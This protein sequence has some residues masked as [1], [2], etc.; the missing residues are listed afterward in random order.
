MFSMIISPLTSIVLTGGSMPSLNVAVD[1][2]TAE[3]RQRRSCHFARAP[4]ARKPCPAMLGRF[5]NSR[6]TN[7]PWAPTKKCG[8]PWCPHEMIHFNG[9]SWKKKMMLLDLG[10]DPMRQTT[11][12]DTLGVS[13]NIGKLHRLPVLI[14][15]LKRTMKGTLW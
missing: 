3:A 7:L 12:W 13:K 1:Q 14:L 11:L 4:M 10:S 5:T 2:S 8:T 9:G 6:S 15:F